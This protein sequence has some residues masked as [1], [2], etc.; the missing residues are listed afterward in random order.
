MSSLQS[1]SP[2]KHS[3]K[4][5]ASLKAAQAEQPQRYQLFPKDKPL[6]T[7]TTLNT[8]KALP[9]PQ[10]PESNGRTSPLAGIRIRLNQ[11]NLVRRR[12]VSVPELGPMTTVQE[13]SMD[14]P[15]IPGRPPLHER[16]ASAPEE[17]S[18]LVGA[19]DEIIKASIHPDNLAKAIEDAFEIPATKP[20]PSSPRKL[21]PLVIP[22][23]D[24]LAPLLKSK[25]SSSQ[26]RSGSTPP[27]DQPRSGRGDAGTPTIGRLTPASTPDLSMPRSATATE[28]TTSTIP[29]PVSAPLVDQRSS[30]HATY[31]DVGQAQNPFGHRR[32]GSEPSNMM[33][34]GRPSKRNEKTCKTKS[35]ERRA[36][37]ELPAGWKPCEAMSKLNANDVV[38]LHKQALGQAERFEV[39]RVEAVDALSKELRQ[40]DDRTEYL[41]RTYSSLRAGRR[42]LHSRICQYLRSPRVAKFSHESMLKQEEALAELDASIDDWVTKLE[43]AENRRTRV[44][45]K[46]LE[47][48]AAAAIL[49]VPDGSAMPYPTQ[50]AAAAAAAAQDVLLSTPPRSPTKQV[51]IPVPGSPRNSP[52]PQRVVAQVPSTILEQP[53]VEEQQAAAAVR[54]SNQPISRATSTAATMS[55]GRSAVESI[56]VYAGDDLYALLA[57]V[58]DEISRLG[59][60]TDEMAAPPRTRSQE[61]L[62]DGSSSPRSAAPSPPPTVEAPSPPPRAVK[63]DFVKEAQMLLTNAVFKP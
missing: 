52:S 36:F 4:S 59:S 35:S 26:L 10:A 16:S 61:K 62:R 29:T 60:S 22:P 47:H 7:P 37:E 24:A 40:L 44:R 13:V 32:A 48:V 2:P 27:S 18:R 19:M 1:S 58:E 38:V 43:Q 3:A 15:T 5:F 51:A 46:L 45:Q 56:R 42:N 9:V 23:H 54:N 55:R 49:P 53:V 6:P 57:D 12:K 8:G 30:P 14:S 11:N 63:K 25:H 39:L 33:D 41:R 31:E 20:R 17:G 50:S 21:A 28:A 34:R